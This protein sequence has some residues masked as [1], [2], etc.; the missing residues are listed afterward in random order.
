MARWAFC[1]WRWRAGLCALF[2]LR[3]GAVDRLGAARVTRAIALIYPLTLIA[4]PLAP[5]VAALGV[6]LFAFGAAHGAMDV[7]MNSWGAEVERRAGRRYMSGFHAM[8]SFG[9][10]VGA[11]SGYGAVQL[12]AGLLA[13]FALTSAVLTLVAMHVALIPWRSDLAAPTDAAAFALPKGPL[14][15][16]GVVAFC[17]ALGEGAMADWSAVY[18]RNVVAVDEGVAALGYAVFSITMVAVRLAGD[19]ITVRLGAVLTARIGGCFAGAGV[20]LAVVMPG[21]VPVLL[22]FALMGLGYGVIMPL[23]FSR[24]A[25]D[26]GIPPGQAIASVATLGYGGMLLGPPVIGFIASVT[27][28]QIAFGVLAILAAVIVAT[29]AALR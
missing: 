14:L 3:G 13:H 24:A 12:D 25:N 19:A 10:G 27:G 6:L 16:V 4:L 20:L 5:G 26:P 18:L 2:L 22:G 29:A 28:L 8:F 23:A 17:S 7:A 11:L 1:C 15:L 9:A 21:P